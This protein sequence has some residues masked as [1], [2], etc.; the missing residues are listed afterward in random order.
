[1]PSLNVISKNNTQN[2]SYL[3]PQRTSGARV[4][5]NLRIEQNEFFFEIKK[6][7]NFRT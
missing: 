7:I 3:P 6:N 1:M 4:K 2:I 5:F